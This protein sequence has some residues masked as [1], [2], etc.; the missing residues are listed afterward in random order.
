MKRRP[1]LAYPLFL[2]LL[3]VMGVLALLGAEKPPARGGELV[4]AGYLEIK[5]LNPLLVQDTLAIHLGDLLFNSL[6]KFNEHFEPVPD[7]AESWRVSADGLAW[8]FFLKKGVRF[9]DGRE[10]TAADAA[11]T[12]NAILDPG[13]R[14]PY[15]ALFHMVQRFE[16]ADRYRFRVVLKAPYA[17]LLFLM[18]KEIL[19]SH[20]VQA[21][22]A[23]ME[24]FGRRPVGSGP[25]RFSEWKNGEIVLLAN[26]DYF[27][28]R[29]LLDRIVARRYPNRLGAW[30][31][32]MQ[33]KVDVVED[34]EYEDYQVIRNDP[35]FRV[36]DYLSRFYYT[37]TFNLQDPLFS[38]PR[39]R[40]AVDLAI[41]R[42]D[43]IDKALQG[44]GLA[45]T[46]PFQPGTWPYNERV[47]DPQYRPQEAL[48][49]LREL[50]WRDSDGDRILDRGGKRLS[51]TLLADSGDSLKE[52]LAK[53]LRWQL[54]QLGIEVQ[55]EFLDL[56]ELFEKK[57]LPGAFQAVLLQYN[58][59]RDPDTR[60]SFFWHS[61]SIGQ[62]N[63]ARYRNER[64]DRLLEQGQVTPGL[65][66]RKD[67]YRTVH[68]LLAEDRPAAFLF[69]RRKFLGISSRF[70]GIRT[71]PELFYQSMRDWYAQNK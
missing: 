10:L 51:F 6:I 26:E 60:T 68:A 47:S 66:E 63:L 52:A 35:R 9:H 17:P 20:L 65:A 56:G 11:F 7:M 21:T 5:N 4:L 2:A 55:V 54:F 36:Y 44:W 49:I 50:G 59:G 39:L 13:L 48:A 40:Q 57:L 16:A 27:E 28:G 71:T 53:R 41:D 67:I 42:S 61:G 18:D 19:P 38:D 34:L 14:T 43:L 32:L 70:G 45:T 3:G 58:V 30:S 24:A 33:G 62:S 64:V 31:A 37:V 12:Y 69:F 29:P 8:E 22:P 15:A 23:S 25:F 46:G 1:R